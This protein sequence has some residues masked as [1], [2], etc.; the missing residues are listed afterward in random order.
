MIVS[1][2]LC[3]Y[4]T[5]TGMRLRHFYDSVVKPEA[6]I[7][8]RLQD[9]DEVTMPHREGWYEQSALIAYHVF[10][11]KSPSASA[12]WVPG[13]T[14]DFGISSSFSGYGAVA[15]EL[16]LANGALREFDAYGTIGRDRVIDPK[17]RFVVRKIPLPDGRVELEVTRGDFACA[18]EDLYD[19]NYEDGEL[20]ANAA[21]L[22]IGYR[23]QGQRAKGK[24]YVHHI[25]ILSSYDSPFS[26]NNFL[27]P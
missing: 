24:I 21:A 26:L 22:Q 10:E 23:E 3:E 8:M 14:L 9:V 18:V 20:P 11:S 5:E 1:N 15:T 4:A 12:T 17:Y 6:E 27:I 25:D 19:F 13:I 7:E 16:A 2:R